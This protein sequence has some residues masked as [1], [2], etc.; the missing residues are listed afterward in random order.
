MVTFE[1]VVLKNFLSFGEDP[2]EVL[3]N[4]D[5]IT[6]IKGNNGAGK[7]TILDAIYFGLYGKSFR[8]TVLKNIIN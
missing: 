3:L 7:S 5:K 8:G 4:T 1:K 6:A 2:V